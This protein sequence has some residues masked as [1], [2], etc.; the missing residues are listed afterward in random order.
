[1]LWNIYASDEAF[2]LETLDAIVFL[3][4][5]FVKCKYYILISYSFFVDK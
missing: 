3:I 2:S 1:M 4:K 5:M